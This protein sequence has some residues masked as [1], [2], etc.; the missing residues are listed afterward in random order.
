MILK[1]NKE[2]SKEFHTRVIKKRPDL[3]K[4]DVDEKTLFGLLGNIMYMLM[5]F[6][7]FN[8]KWVIR[9]RRFSLFSTKKKKKNPTVSVKIRNALIQKCK[10]S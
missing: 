4:Y 5:F 1:F 2:L 9:L 7:A 6:L 3:L 10:V 8:N